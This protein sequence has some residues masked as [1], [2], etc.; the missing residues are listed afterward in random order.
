MLTTY[1]VPSENWDD[2]FEF[3]Q[4]SSPSSPN[5]KRDA[6]S[7]PYSS[8]HHAR[9]SQTSMMDFEPSLPPS[10][11]RMSTT[12]S[13]ISEDWDAESSANL[14]FEPDLDVHMRNPDVGYG[15][16]H[17]TATNPPET[18]PSKLA[19]TP[20]SASSGPDL[21]PIDTQ[22]PY[23]QPPRRP[24]A[25]ENWDDDFEDRSDTPVR[26]NPTRLYLRPSSFA[27]DDSIAL[28]PTK[29][30]VGTLA[31]KARGTGSG[32]RCVVSADPQDDYDERPES[33]DE[34]FELDA[35]R[36]QEERERSLA[37]SASQQE[38]VPS[39]GKRRK[40]RRSRQSAGGYSSYSSSEEEDFGQVYEPTDHPSLLHSTSPGFEDAE[41]GI[42]E[43]E[44]DRTVT[45]RSRRRPFSRLL[46]PSSKKPASPP[47]PVPSIPFQHLSPGHS[48]PSSA[49][50]AQPHT[51][52]SSLS[53]HPTQ[54]RP[55]PRSPNPSV[56]SIPLPSTRSASSAS[57]S[58]AAA[59]H[60][61]SSVHSQ[62]HSQQ[63]HG[64][65]THSSKGDETGSLD[66]SQGNGSMTHL[67]ASL[68]RRKSRTSFLGGLPPSSPP[69]ERR[70]LRKKS[71]PQ[72]TNA[73]GG[74][75]SL[76]DNDAIIP[77]DLGMELEE[78]G[79]SATVVDKGRRAGKESLGGEREWRVLTERDGQDV[80]LPSDSRPMSPR[81]P[82][83]PPPTH[84]QMQ[85]QTAG[86]Q[87]PSTP[88]GSG[89]A[90]PSS[91][92]LLSR[93][94]SVKRWGVRRK[95]GSTTPSEVEAMEKARPFPTQEGVPESTPRP[96]S[97]LSSLNGSGIG[98]PSSAHYHDYPDSRP[99]PS[100]PSWFFKAA[101]K[102]HG[103]NESTSDLAKD[104]DVTWER[105]VE[106]RM[107]YTPSPEGSHSRESNKLMKRKSLGFVPLRRYG[108]GYDDRESP[109]QRGR[110]DVVGAS[111]SSGR[112]LSMQPQSRHASYGDVGPSRTA[113]ESV[114]DFL[115][116]DRSRRKSSKS[117][118]GER[119][120]REEG[121]RG[122][123]GSVR[124]LSLVG[125]H[126]RTKSGVSLASIAAGVAAALGPLPSTPVA[127]VPDNQVEPHNKASSSKNQNDE[128]KSSDLPPPPTTAP[129]SFSSHPPASPLSS[130][131]FV[132]DG[133]EELHPQPRLATGTV[134]EAADP[135][136]T[137]AD[138]VLLPPIELHP[139]SPPRTHAEREA[140]SSTI[141]AG[142]R[143]V[144]NR[145]R[146]TVFDAEMTESTP[147]RG[148]D[149][150]ILSTTSASPASPF[151]ALPPVITT[152]EDPDKTIQEQEPSTI[153]ASPST[154]P[155][156][157]LAR[158]VLTRSPQSGAPP[159][160]ASLGRSTGGPVSLLTSSVNVGS[161]STS[162]GMATV[163]RRNSLGDLKIPARI[164]QAQVGLRRDLG[165]VKEFAANIDQLRELQRTYHGLVM[166]VQHI[167]DTQAHLYAQQQQQLRQQHRQ[168]MPQSPSRAAS[169]TFFGRSK[170]RNR[171][172]SQAQSRPQSAISTST[173]STTNL[174]YKQLASAFYTINSK[175]RI[176]W[177]CA[178]LL[179]ELGSGPSHP[180]PSTGPS[181]FRYKIVGSGGAS[182]ASTGPSTSVSA[183]VVQNA[184][185]STVTLESKKTG[186]ERAV[187]LGADESKPSSLTPYSAPV[188]SSQSTI[189]VS[190]IPG[191][192]TTSG[193]PMPDPPNLSWR[194]STGRHDLSHRQLLLLKEMLN[195]PE[196]GSGNG[197]AELLDLEMSEIATN[198]P[199]YYHHTQRHRAIPEESVT[200]LLLNVN[201]EWRW[202]DAMSSTVTLP[203]EDGSIMGG[204]AMSPGF[205]A[206]V[207]A[208]LGLGLK[209]KGKRR[210]VGISGL[211]SI[212]RSLKRSHS[213]N[214]QTPAIPGS[215][216]HEIAPP[217]PDPMPSAQHSAAS[218]EIEDALGDGP[219]QHRYPHPL[220][221][222]PTPST[223]PH[224]PSGSNQ[225]QTQGGRRAKTSTGPES[226]GN[227]TRPASPYQASL[228]ASKPSPRRPSIASIFRLG[229]NTKQ[230]HSAHGSG[231]TSPYT[232]DM[233]L[234]SIPG[235]DGNSPGHAGQASRKLRKK[236]GSRTGQV[237]PDVFAD[238]VSSL[239]D[240]DDDDW[241]RIDSASDLGP[242]SEVDV[243]ATVRKNAGRRV[244]LKGR[245]RSPY[246][247]R[248]HGGYFGGTTSAE[249]IASRSG[250]RQGSPQ[251]RVAS[252]THS[253]SSLWD[254]PGSGSS[255]Q[256]GA[257][258]SARPSRLSNV[259]E[260]A[261]SMRK[262]D[263]PTAIAIAAPA[264]IPPS[265]TSPAM[266]TSKTLHGM[267]IPRPSTGK[268]TRDP[269][270]PAD[271]KLAMTPENIRP[272]L[273]NAREVRARLGECVAEIRGLLA[274]ATAAMSSPTEVST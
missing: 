16:A 90:S 59:S 239:G 80:E 73:N 37:K 45:A 75:G 110:D 65:S 131:G 126:K 190:S 267:P 235:E 232:G 107:M 1:T 118:D 152:I 258:S 255:H 85:P 150:A 81:T 23:T 108:A 15:Y 48:L 181:S 127:T 74:E 6:S 86:K 223:P 226:D 233:S 47:P 19:S 69:R 21:R 14:S 153:T 214:H 260:D 237:R 270:G 179:I 103:R 100:N 104:M 250:S 54:S 66:T 169:P 245:G 186:R 199:I 53:A 115:S 166:E 264:A 58:S 164:S 32:L 7:T 271:P 10:R 213:D 44:E 72:A 176:S 175:Y 144:L 225:E 40:L 68:G 133:N 105:E 154:S 64:Y 13:F 76:I 112:P 99:P 139:P 42:G 79:G 183:P 149:E 46:S 106:R 202:G 122:F 253:S 82:A 274:S 247:Q 221:P 268:G 142:S 242:A 136:A 4:A 243:F 31:S 30:T 135:T 228:T 130:K 197:I 192:S 25:T 119:D 162:S 263:P 252:A 194:A 265:N 155:K 95:R 145:S 151:Q 216:H 222:L 251:R 230:A 229:K 210:L 70:R 189:N 168:S 261:D 28:T 170:T 273:E 254:S 211:K 234:E 159:Q 138:G 208:G 17:G 177:E 12:S 200:S 116:R 191:P 174:A 5:S 272:L 246:L 60:T 249:R 8:I 22:S 185:T 20:S 101:N 93:I 217:L 148:L 3:Q 87:V 61:S 56:F 178:E 114:E 120:E 26:P 141:T 201:R 146:S 71:R 83:T 125:R 167:L 88:S 256:L 195:N 172:N 215:P 51:S 52:P 97:S 111:T 157:S 137:R 193:P 140:T 41:F 231:T 78:E 121:S 39:P 262:E 173:T 11:T 27:S 34:E 49:S 206:G 2:D 102:L 57:T 171:S 207:A 123:M 50:S 9:T 129:A 128:V 257:G 218:L 55:F 209:T 29:A 35:L 36:E 224:D 91:G 94:G 196:S 204:R 132:L 96:Q 198:Y 113:M 266:S 92:G 43:R 188:G 124:K 244:L 220:L 205:G 240:G 269:S 165:M 160:T 117:R 24:I 259:E 62:P 147:M 84:Q 203:S 158:S 134:I 227:Q 241:D 161:V 156:D 38:F 219:G 67:L 238:S 109:M 236:G 143:A 187:T 77:E 180:A 33:W 18:P 212:L 98:T 63:S 89:M 248:D 182:N 184:S 163:H